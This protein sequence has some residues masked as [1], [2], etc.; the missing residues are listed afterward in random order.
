MTKALFAEFHVIEGNEEKVR[1]LVAELASRVR[2]E[3]GN[4][5]FEAHTLASNP[6]HYFV[7]EVYA[8]DAAFRAHLEQEHGRIFNTALEPLVEGGASSLTHLATI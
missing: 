3:P 4:I 5:A 1:T 8:D 2:E 7:Y 6:N